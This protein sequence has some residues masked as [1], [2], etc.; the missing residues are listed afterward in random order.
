MSTYVMHIGRNAG[1]YGVRETTEDLL[2]WQAPDAS[3]SSAAYLVA[4]LNAH[5]R[6]LGAHQA[7][8]ALSVLGS[9]LPAL[10]TPPSAVEGDRVRCGHAAVYLTEHGCAMCTAELRERDERVS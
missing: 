9:A 3:A 5:A 1:P 7:R 6:H 4:F 2:V 10:D 8:R